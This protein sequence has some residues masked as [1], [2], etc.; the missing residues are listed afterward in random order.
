MAKT[1]TQLDLLYKHVM[2]GG[3]KSI[4]AIGTRSG[5]ITRIIPK[6]EALYD[7]EIHYMGNQMGGSHLNYPRPGGNQ[8]D[9]KEMDNA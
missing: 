2:E 8:G 4:S 6:F 3:F 1:M 9:N 7:E 5:H